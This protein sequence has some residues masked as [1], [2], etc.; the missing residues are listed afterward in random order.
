M[1]VLM[2]I[3]IPAVATMAAIHIWRWLH[4]VS[5]NRAQTITE[6][7]KQHSVV[8]RDFAGG[9]THLRQEAISI[10]RHY[11]PHLGVRGTPEMRFMAEIDNPCPDLGL[12]SQ[13]RRELV[14]EPA[15]N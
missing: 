5:V 15:W 7:S 2:W 10:H 12:R 13:Y 3:V 14:G 1:I 8:I 6:M 11:I 9:E 4:S